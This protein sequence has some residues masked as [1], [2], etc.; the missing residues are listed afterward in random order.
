MFLHLA[1][2]R[3]FFLLEIAL[4][5]IYV[6]PAL[7]LTTL[8]HL[9]LLFVPILNLHALLALFPLV[10]IEGL[11]PLRHLLQQ[12]SLPLQVLHFLLNLVLLPLRD[13][14]FDLLA[15]LLASVHFVD[16]CF[17]MVGLDPRLN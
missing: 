12:K 7:F 1:A 4:D 2:D 3:C 10:F 16:F 8:R 9:K 13:Y 6:F 11:L 5:L 17:L 15:E 14:S